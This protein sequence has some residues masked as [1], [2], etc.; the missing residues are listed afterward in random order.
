[1]SKG[2]GQLGNVLIFDNRRESSKEGRRRAKSKL[3][4][5]MDVEEELRVMYRNEL[6]R[7]MDGEC[8]EI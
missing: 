3:K 1:M 2:D 6:G 4:M 7:W 8:S 5:S